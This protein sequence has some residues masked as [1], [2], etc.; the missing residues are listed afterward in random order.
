[1]LLARPRLGRIRT[2]SAAPY[3]PLLLSLL[4]EISVLGARPAAV[5]GPV[6][7]V[8]GVY[9]SEVDPVRWTDCL[10]GRFGLLGHLGLIGD[11]R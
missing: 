2:H 9:R 7:I 1:M 6:W 10:L 11:R 4:E 5:A 3:V 8:Q